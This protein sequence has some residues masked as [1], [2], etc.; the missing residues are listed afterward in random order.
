MNRFGQIQLLALVTVVMALAMAAT[1]GCRGGDESE[2]AAALGTTAVAQMAG[3]DG[4]AM[5][6][7]TLTQGKQGVLV[8]ADVT[9]LLPGFHGFHIHEIGQCAPD[10]TAAGDHFNPD[11]ER[12]HGFLDAGGYHAGDMPNIYAT[13]DGTAKAD[14]FNGS[15]S[16]A[17]GVEHSL[18]DA[19][20]SAVIIH[21]KADTYGSDA[22]A[23]GRVACGVIRRN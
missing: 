14:V 1:V 16:L 19:D 8:A 23:G 5:G 4:S 9:G 15:V 12:G 7:V 17:E 20:G 22:G 6:V 18:F 3:P 2:V 11:A 13:P 10:F 21:E